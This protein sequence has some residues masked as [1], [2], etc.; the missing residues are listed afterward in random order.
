VGAT[1]LPTVHAAVA[2]KLAQRNQQ[3]SPTMS[4]DTTT[5]TEHSRTEHSRDDTTTSADYAGGAQASPQMPNMPFGEVGVGN[6]K[7]AL[8]LQTEMFDV[9]HD[10][11][12][13][14][15]ARATSEAEFAFGLPNKLTAAQTVPDALSAYHE[16]LNE[17]MNMCSEDS[18]RFIADS[19]RIMDKSVGCFSGASH[20][21]TT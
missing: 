15:V 8:R 20:G 4:D 2:I 18:R 13:N 7:A 6:V 10:I 9:L 1:G 3:R 11:G 14:W 19:Q 12:R 21:A 16:W 17:W 5:F